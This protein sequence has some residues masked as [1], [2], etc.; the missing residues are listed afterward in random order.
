[1]FGAAAAAAGELGAGVELA[2]VAGEEVSQNQGN[3]RG[4]QGGGGRAAAGGGAAG[5]LGGAA[6]G[7]G[8]AAGGLGRAAGGLGGAADKLLQTADKLLQSADNV[9]LPETPQK[10]CG[11]GC[12]TTWEGRWWRRKGFKTGQSRKGLKMLTLIWKQLWKDPKMKR[13]K[14]P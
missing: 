13:T 6:G 4:S 10:A 2:A 12:F 7:L 14:K 3:L 9:L 11:W 1:M 5:G 8:R